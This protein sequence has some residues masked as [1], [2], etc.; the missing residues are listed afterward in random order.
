MVTNL[1]WD[2]LAIKMVKLRIMLLYK[3]QRQIIAIPDNI[4]LTASDSSSRT[5]GQHEYHHHSKMC[6]QH[7]SS[8]EASGTGTDFHRQQ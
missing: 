7:S 1:K 8:R 3:I 4:Y 6:I 5:K 2:P